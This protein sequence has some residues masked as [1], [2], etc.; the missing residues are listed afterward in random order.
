VAPALT[1]EQVRG[2]NPGAFLA[3]PVTRVIHLGEGADG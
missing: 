1:A 3:V 2:L